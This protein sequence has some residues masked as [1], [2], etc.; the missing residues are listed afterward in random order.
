MKT[1]AFIPARSGSKGIVGKNIKFICGKPLIAWSIEHAKASKKVD[2]VYVSTNC[3]E[4]ARISKDYGAKV[5]FLRPDNIS[6]DHSTTESAVE[7]FCKFLDEQRFDYENI[8]LIQ[9]TSPIRAAGRFDD[10]IANFESR[11]LDSLV[12]VSQANKFIWKNFE[13]PTA[14]YNFL[15]RPRRQDIPSSDKSFVETGSFYLF[16]KIV[17]TEIK[18]R[19]CGTFGL[20]MTPEEES[21]DIDTMLDFVICESLIK[22]NKDWRNFAS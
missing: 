18:N 5:P 15:R 22:S 14:D 19:I 3:Q 17:F 10:A 1:V 8:L 4:I 6:D 7:H 9:C 12:P 20:Y 2:E 16:K 11:Q 13:A 21:F